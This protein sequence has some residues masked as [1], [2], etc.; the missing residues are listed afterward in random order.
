MKYLNYIQKHDDF[1]K[2]MP[3]DLKKMPTSTKK[4]KAYYKSAKKREA[5]K[6]ANR[7]DSIFLM[8]ERK[9]GIKH[10]SFC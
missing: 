7:L 9:E 4:Q 8:I 2:K 3:D 6:A 5:R 1:K 10:L